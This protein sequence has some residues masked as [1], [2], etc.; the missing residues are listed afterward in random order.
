M[1]RDLTAEIRGLISQHPI[2]IFM[3]G[4]RSSPLCGFSA[5]AV[6]IFDVLGVSYETVDVLSDPAM[7]EAV[8]SFS[9][10]PTIPQVYVR[11]QFLGGSDTLREMYE[12]GEL[13]TLVHSAPKHH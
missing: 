1:P 10:W 5:T 13:E 11:G 3:K 6:R 12:R 7:R 9:S 2:L 4:N 8:K